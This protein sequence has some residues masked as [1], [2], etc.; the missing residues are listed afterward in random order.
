MTEKST[1]AGVD[2]QTGFALQRNA[3]L[4]LL[5]ENYENKFKEKDYFICL[6]HH[7][8]FLFCF[9]NENNEAEVIEVYQSKKKSPE[10]WRLNDE[11]NEIIRKILLTGRAL[12]DDDFPKSSNYKHLLFFSTNQTIN[13][14]V[15][16]KGK[17]VFSESIKE[18]NANVKFVSLHKKIR[19]KITNGIND[20]T[21][22][23]ELEK[24]NFIWIDLNRTVEK[25]KNEL[26][27]QVGRVFGDKISN[28]VAAVKTL[29]LLFEEI[30]E[31]YNQGNKAKLL[32]ESKRVTSQQI[33]KAFDILTSQ[34]KCFD[35]WRNQTNNISLILQIKPFE[36]DSFELDF[37]TSFDFFKNISDAEHRMILDFV[38]SN[39]RKCTTFTTEG[40]V[41][42]LTDMF[43]K[44]E[45]TLFN[46][47]KLKA[48]I[49][50]AYFEATFKR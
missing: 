49:F 34:S 4:Y 28:H 40:N 41:N 33:E 30:E 22:N 21:L 3:A 17:V 42:E 26:V 10:I 9:L 27:G 7:D 19:E 31:I 25:Q 36:Q 12:L 13:L 8:D 45:T 47:Q 43:Y 39:Y 15:E 50:A 14:K 24:L 38:K 2:A 32:D 16:E 23:E 6:E 44:T 18:N 20:P 37:T 29:I 35:Y 48:I 5:L 46:T 11:L 1:N